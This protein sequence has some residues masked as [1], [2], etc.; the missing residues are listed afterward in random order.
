M[1]ADKLYISRDADRNRPNT[2]PRLQTLNTSTIIRIL[3]GSSCC[4]TSHNMNLSQDAMKRYSMN[5]SPHLVQAFSHFQA[6]TTQLS[7]AI[8]LH[9]HMLHYSL[10]GIS[11][12]SLLPVADLCT[13]FSK[14]GTAQV[15]LTHAS[16]TNPEAKKWF[17]SSCPKPSHPEHLDRFFCDQRKSSLVQIAWVSVHM[18]I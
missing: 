9:V 2:T 1:N 13:D 16:Q 15:L 7:N 8:Y 4:Y 10:L 6:F 17:I 12:C 3:T 11:Q 18:K 5:F 14:P